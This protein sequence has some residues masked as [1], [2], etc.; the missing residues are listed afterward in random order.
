[1]KFQNNIINYDMPTEIGMSG[2]PIIDKVNGEYVIIG[3][4][5]YVRK[6]KK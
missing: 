3:I 6:N 1:M 4:H 5:T 2:A